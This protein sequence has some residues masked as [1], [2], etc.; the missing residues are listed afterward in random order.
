MTWTKICGTTNLDDARLAI[1]AG[2]DAVGF[3]FAPSRR[4]IRQE[5]AAEIIE[6][7]PNEIAKIGVTVNQSPD[8]VARLAET[9]G[10]TWI[11][12]QGDEPADQLQ[13]YRSALAP[14]K[15]VKTL[16]ARQVLAGGEDYVYRYLGE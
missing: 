7:L 12:L 5:T 14:R 6:V 1:S 11:Q 16:P 3:V 2:A 10:L 9:V 4:Q 15:I 8:A 13:A